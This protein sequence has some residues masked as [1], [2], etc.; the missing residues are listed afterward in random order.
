MMKFKKVLAIAVA[1]LMVFGS[2]SAAFAQSFKDVPN[3]H[4][5]YQYIHE[6][7]NKNILNGYS[8]GT[9]KPS[10]YVT[11]DQSISLMMNMLG[12]T[13]HEKAQYMSIYKD[14]L[15]KAGFSAWVQPAL[16]VALGRGIVLENEL[17]MGNITREDFALF[18]AR[19]YR[20]GTTNGQ[21]ALNNMQFPD[22]MMITPAAVPA[23]FELNKHGIIG[24]TEAGTFNPKGMITRAEAAKMLSV[25]DSKLIKPMAS[26]YV[27]VNPTFDKSKTT[28]YK[29]TIE[30]VTVYGDKAYVYL[31][32]QT[33]TKKRFTIGN[34]TEK[35]EDDGD[36]A[37]LADFKEGEYVEITTDKN[38]LVITAK[39]SDDD[40]DSDYSGEITSLS[41]SR[42]EIKI[43]LSSG[44]YK[45]FEFDE[46]DVKVYIDGDREKLKDLG[47]GDDVKLELDKRGDVIKI[48]K[49][50]DDDDNIKGEI[51]RIDKSDDEIKIDL[52]HGGT[53]TYEMAKHA[54]IKRKGKTVDDIGDLRE[55]D[56][57]EFDID[58]HDKI[59][60]IYAEGSKS[61]SSDDGKDGDDIDAYILEI[62][63]G[64]SYS[65]T[66]IN[67]DGEKVEFDD[68][69]FDD[70]KLKVKG[71]KDEF[72]DLKVGYKVTY[73]ADDGEL[74]EV[75][76]KDDKYKLLEG[77]I[78]R[79]YD[80]K[81]K[82]EDE[83]DDDEE[84]YVKITSRTD[85]FD[86]DEDEIDRDD[87][88]DKF[89]KNDDVWIFYDR[90]R[91][92]GDDIDAA[93]IRIK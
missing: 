21:I 14:Y 6:L 57:V 77:E 47:R 23:V 76:V 91:K 33:T 3:N 1:G 70:D 75:D 44:K 67:E 74:E 62:D 32:A 55:D 24:G 80:D 53:K 28:D 36:K 18:L 11:K 39:L 92:S 38:D 87:V 69:D 4:W 82:V 45:T 10:Q 26:S 66:F 90:D 46:D 49:D 31:N 30:S 85:M 19:S 68:D 25:A 59:T 58:S 41:T 40:D 13:A 79:V 50:D 9:F 43:K 81:L 2:G 89:D 78:K 65:I 52:D 54:K 42:E 88:D 15:T 86:N 48:T 20:I 72:D 63:D 64:K 37:D 8:D 51:L 93:F 61:S 60:R 35:L 29:G 83:D 12:V 17:T 84:Y 56:K 34:Y 5:A 71:D 22:K 73:S 27:P 16:S 7:S